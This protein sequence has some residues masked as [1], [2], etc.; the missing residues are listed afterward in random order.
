MKVRLKPQIN[1]AI[2][3]ILIILF[4][5]LAFFATTNLISSFKGNKQKFVM[6]YKINND[7]N[8][9]V[10]LTDNDFYQMEYLEKDK[11]YPSKVISNIK[12]NIL[13]KYKS[14]TATKLSYTYK[15]TGKMISEAINKDADNEEIWNKEYIIIDETKKEIESNEILIDEVFNIDYRYYENLMEKYKKEFA[16][17]MDAYFKIEY[18]VLIKDEKNDIEK[19]F[20]STSSIP[21]LEDTFKIDTKIAEEVNDNI[22]SEQK[23]SFV[24]IGLLLFTAILYLLIIYLI[25]KTSKIN[26]MSAYLLKLNKILKMYNDIIITVEELPEANDL[27]VIDLKDFES[28]VDLEQEIRK[29]I[30]YARIDESLNVFAI[31]TSSFVYRYVFDEE[32]YVWKED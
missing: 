27:E 5:L 7:V 16:V 23:L 32:E 1:L 18:S 14:S 21:L 11:Q 10:Y 22:Y 20:I 13:T 12:Y 26:F 19:E 3:I 2:N 31:Y 15:V 9:K 25:I 24:N 8:Y 28:L 4:G 30:M 6:N 29:P 17:S